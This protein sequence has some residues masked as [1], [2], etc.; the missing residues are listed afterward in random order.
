MTAFTLPLLTLSPRGLLDIRNP[1][2]C[3]TSNSD[4]TSAAI[5]KV[6]PLSASER[7]SEIRGLS[8][9]VTKSRMPNKSKRSTFSVTRPSAASAHRFD[10]CA[11]IQSFG[12]LIFECPR[13][14]SL[15]RTEVINFVA[16]CMT[17]SERGR[18]QGVNH[19]FR[20]LFLRRPL[21]RRVDC[22]FRRCAGFDGA[23]GAARGRRIAEPGGPHPPNTTKR[24]ILSWQD[25]HDYLGMSGRFSIVQHD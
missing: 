1:A 22:R 8:A 23:R 11:R 6:P 9:V 19:N 24:T 7:P 25:R 16:L 21:G 10:A 5:Q 18:K 17:G 4:K 14:A 2:K 20:P 15:P 12:A 3:R 13:T